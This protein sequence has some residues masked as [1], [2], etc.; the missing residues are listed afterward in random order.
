MADRV[1]PRAPGATAPLIALLLA[2]LAACGGA[3]SVENETS[4][5]S[6]VSITVGSKEFTEQ[7]ILGH[8][9]ILLLEDK[10]AR[11]TDK[12]G[13]HGTT[14][15]RN[16]LVSGEIDMYWEYTG[17]G[18]SNILGRS[19]ADAPKDGKEIY[20]MVADE[21]LEKNGVKWLALAPLNNTY[22][23]A[24]AHGRG[25][26]L[27]VTNLSDYAELANRSPKQ[28]SLCAGTEF[29]TRDD[30]LPGLQ[31]TYAFDLPRRAVSQVA[32]GVVYTEIPKG[33]ACNFGE[34]YATD[35]RVAANDLDI[36][37]DDKSHF[38]KY[39]VAPTMRKQIYQKHPGL[40]D[41]FQPLTESLTTKTMQRLNAEVDV[42]GKLPEQVAE[43]YLEKNHLVG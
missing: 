41:I 3:G 4:S 9:A 13:I 30:G 14:N 34:V 17:T 38:V 6:G 11:V 28:A 20:R 37:E 19:T 18:W 22:A 16:A 10:G 39:N 27:G 21:D 5:L 15:V 12:T 29:L 31:R 42:Q 40:S 35:G 26:Q 7:L 2:V 33:N 23:I 36:V 1:A 24:T 8:M 25:A 43:D 32:A